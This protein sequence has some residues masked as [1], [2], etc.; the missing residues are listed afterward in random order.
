MFC[1][2]LKFHAKLP[3]LNTIGKIDVYYNKVSTD[4]FNLYLSRNNY[5][6]VKIFFQDLNFHIVEDVPKYALHG[7]I[8][9]N[10]HV[11]T[12]KMNVNK[13]IVLKMNI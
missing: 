4:H 2:T 6:Q 1:A 9:K 8:G 3:F 13:V 12:Y 10:D 5:A 11:Y 7:L